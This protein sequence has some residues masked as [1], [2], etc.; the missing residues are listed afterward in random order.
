MVPVLMM[1]LTCIGITAGV[2]KVGAVMPV[3]G[4]PQNNFI[5]FG[6]HQHHFSK[7]NHLGPLCSVKYLMPQVNQWISGS[8]TGDNC[9]VFLGEA[10]AQLSVSCTLCHTHC[11][12]KHN[13][14]HDGLWSI[15]MW[16]FLRQRVCCVSPGLRIRPQTFHTRWQTQSIAALC[17][18][19][20][21]N[22][23][24]ISTNMTSN[25]TESCNEK[26]PTCK[27]TSSAEV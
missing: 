5:M 24:R 10:C 25:M 27:L 8:W 12:C 2:P 22:K 9:R 3:Q 19:S 14:T 13:C 7:F 20:R 23:T 18:I 26:Q 11:T 17:S 6:I 21:S 16:S 15:R 1:S 4:C